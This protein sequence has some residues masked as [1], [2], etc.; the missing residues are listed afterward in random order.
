[1][2]PVNTC[3]I[4]EY[5]NEKL[6]K[7]LFCN[8]DFKY[9]LMNSYFDKNDY[10]INP[11]FHSN[12]DS[13]LMQNYEEDLVSEM[14]MYERISNISN[15]KNEKGNKGVKDAKKFHVKSK[16]ISEFDSLPEE[17]KQGS[18]FFNKIVEMSDLTEKDVETFLEINEKIKSENVQKASEYEKKREEYER[19]S[20]NKNLDNS[21]N[22]FEFEEPDTKI[23]VAMLGTLSKKKY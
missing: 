5:I 4:N 10:R 16:N 19:I 2:N 11:I 3:V 13:V 8:N 14:I 23:G 18:E 1:M 12:K 6:I 9:I 15:K 7:G 20:K 21:E 22:S 17:L